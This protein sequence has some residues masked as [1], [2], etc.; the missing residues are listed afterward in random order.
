[1][2]HYGF[3]SD[4]AAKQYGYHVYRTPDGREVYVTAIY[5]DPEGLGYMFDDKYKVGVVSEYVRSVN[6]HS[7]L[8]RGIDDLKKNINYYEDSKT[9]SRGGSWPR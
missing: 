6:P 2:T 1:M 3:Y 7:N 4:T 5:D 8:N 9:R